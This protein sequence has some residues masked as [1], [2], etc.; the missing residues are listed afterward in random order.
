MI[1]RELSFNVKSLVSVIKQVSDELCDISGM[2]FISY[3][4]YDNIHIDIRYAVTVGS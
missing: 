3:L 4:S 2:R 1:L